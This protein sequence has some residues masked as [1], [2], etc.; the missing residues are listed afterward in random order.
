MNTKIFIASG[1]NALRVALKNLLLRE[2][3][4]V[5]GEGEDSSSTLRGVRTI[6]PDLVILDMDLP[7]MGGLGTAKIL[8]E[9]RITP[10]LLLTP[11]WQRELIQKAKEFWSLSF[12]V[13]P[14]TEAHLLPAVEIAINSFQKM[15]ELEKEVSRLKETLE[16]RKVVEKAKGILMQT[17]GISEAQAFKRI[18]QQAMNKSMP[19]KKIAEAII[20]SQ[21]LNTFKK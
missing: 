11:H 3:Y 7:G 4:I 12:S 16:T 19:M 13:K 6:I 10:I 21:E 20:L 17:L 2:G 1:D 15:R 5:V 9:D 14:V 18:Q 8:E